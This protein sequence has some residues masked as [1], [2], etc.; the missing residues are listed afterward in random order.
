LTIILLAYNKIRN[1]AIVFYKGELRDMKKL[2]VIDLSGQPADIG[3]S[4]GMAMSEQIKQNYRLYLDMIHNNTGLSEPM[5]L[6]LAK[7]FL[8]EIEKTA[9]ELLAEM[10]GTARGARVSLETILVLNSRS[11]LAFPDQLA[12]Q[13]TVI[14]LTAEKT[15]CDRAVIAQNWDWLPAVKENSAFFRIQPHNGP[16]ALILAEAGQVGKIGFNEHGLGVVINLLVSTGIRLGTPT[17]ILLRKL[18]SA[19]DMAEAVLMVKDAQWASSCH[20]LLGDAQGNI[21]GLEASPYGVGEIKPQQGI[22][23]HTNHFCDP[24][25]S[26]KDLAPDLSVDTINRLN[27]AQKLVTERKQWDSAGIKQ[28]LSDHHQKPLSICRHE[29]PEIPQHLRMATL[30]SLL[31]DLQNR[32]AEVAYGQPCRTEYYRLSL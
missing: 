21:I 19:T 1:F 32:T 25:M 28:I 20:M 3:F 12:M 18:L 23:V 22:V 29:D 15:V 9:P 2:P 6:D 30:V 7:R 14:G 26:E 8:P 10:E 31:I 4:H 24:S 17:H 16:R 11:E 13:C 5:I 27:R